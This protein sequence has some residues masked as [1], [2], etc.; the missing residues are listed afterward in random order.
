MA[1]QPNAI[2]TV[3]GSAYWRPPNRLAKSRFC[4]NAC[5][6]TCR[7][8]IDKDEL[9]RLYYDEQLS[10]QQV[11]ERLGCS[12]GKVAY[13]MDKY[14]FKRRSWSQATYV[15]RNPDGD[16]FQI[17]KR[18][19]AEEWK[20]FGVGIG[21]YMGEGSKTGGS[22]SIA[23]TNPG[24][25]RIFI[26]FLELICGVPREKLGAWL[27]IYDDCHVELATKWW[28]KQL[29][30]SLEQFAKP[31]VR[32]SRGGTHK[33][34]S[35][36]GTLTVRFGNLKLKKIILNWCEEYYQQFRLATRQP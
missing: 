22:V 34:K 15:Y 16:P 4:S 29:N 7:K 23:N 36:Y 27:N 19:T 14:N 28:A 32:E 6:H 18:E 35:I 8:K 11:A 30:L 1:R 5:K 21:I 33:Q 24:I 25:H 10:M 17:R 13:W 9:A 31:Q 12:N 20:L 26:T 3:C 2:C